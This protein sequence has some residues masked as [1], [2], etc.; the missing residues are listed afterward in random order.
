MIKATLVLT[1]GVKYLLYSQ[2]QWAKQFMPK[3]KI[4]LNG[5]M[6]NRGQKWIFRLDTWYLFLKDNKLYFKSKEQQFE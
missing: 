5:Q 1:Y 2:F 3:T 6:F 4:C